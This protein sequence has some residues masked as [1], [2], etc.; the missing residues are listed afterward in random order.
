MVPSGENLPL[1]YGATSS[2]TLTFDHNAY[3]LGAGTIIAR[4]YAGAS[5][6][7]DQTF[8]QWQ[9]LGKDCINS[10]LNANLQL[11]ND[12]PQAGS[13]LFNEGIDLGPGDDLTGTLYAHRNTI[14][15]YEGTSTYLAAQSITGFSPIANVLAGGSQFAPITLP[16][17]TA[18]GLAITYTVVSGPATVSGNTLTPS[19]PNDITVLATQAGN[20]T[21]AALSET[22][23]L[24][25]APS[26]GV[27]T[28]TMPAWALAMLAMLL[29]V[30]A[31][32]PSRRA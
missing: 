25:A 1:L 11:Q 18:S 6:T 21:Y 29:A 15:A 20:S 24:T 8:A 3:N 16:A 5:S 17:M 4:A 26:A 10:S 12:I 2:D 13:P 23:T 7:S 19:G 9:A 28:P 14:G 32:R 22:E 30:M 27:D 31:V